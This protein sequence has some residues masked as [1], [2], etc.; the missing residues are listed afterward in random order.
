MITKARKSSLR[1]Y[2]NSRSMNSLSVQERDDLRIFKDLLD[3][4]DEIE[5]FLLRI[6]YR[7]QNPSTNYI[8]NLL[9]E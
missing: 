3:S 5:K 9:G 2:I 7:D 8:L 6:P 4:L 1:E